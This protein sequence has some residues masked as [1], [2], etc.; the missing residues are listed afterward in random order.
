ME[1]VGL[2]EDVESS[3]EHSK[4]YSNGIPDVKYYDSN[5]IEDAYHNVAM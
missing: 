5:E 4:D 3:L 2:F 1:S